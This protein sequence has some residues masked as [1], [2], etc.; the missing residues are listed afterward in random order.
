MRLF[1][2]FSFL[3]GRV[4]VRLGEYDTEK[5]KDCIEIDG[6]EDCSDPPMDFGITCKLKLTQMKMIEQCIRCYDFI[7]SNPD[8][9][10]T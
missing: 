5:E 2:V 1:L 10:T 4:F 8:S 7:Y 6:Q 9:S 3:F